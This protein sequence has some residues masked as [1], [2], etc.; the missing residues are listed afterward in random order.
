VP[1]TTTDAAFGVTEI[2]VKT[3]AVDESL[4]ATLAPPPQADSNAREITTS[5]KANAEDAAREFLFKDMRNSL[6]IK[7][8]GEFAAEPLNLIY[9]GDFVGW[10]HLAG[11]PG[12]VKAV[13]LPKQKRLPGG[14]EESHSWLLTA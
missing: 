9:L 7:L 12:E 10:R 1:P 8:C 14:D 5:E 11:H 3:G 13:G 4:A 2:V 6:D